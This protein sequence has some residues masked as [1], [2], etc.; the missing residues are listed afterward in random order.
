MQIDG[1]TPYSFSRQTKL[2]ERSFWLV[3][4]GEDELYRVIKY[5]IEAESM[6]LHSNRNELKDIKHPKIGPCTIFKR[7]TH[8][9]IITIYRY[10]Y[11]IAKAITILGTRSRKLP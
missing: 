2:H 8:Y 6:P 3:K 5:S 4:T 11:G 10:G 7:C 1:D 9:N